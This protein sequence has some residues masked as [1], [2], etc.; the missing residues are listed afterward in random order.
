M[1]MSSHSCSPLRLLAT[2]YLFSFSMESPLLDT[3]HRQDRRTCGL[4][5]L[6]SLAQQ[7]VESQCAVA[8]LSAPL[9]F[10]AA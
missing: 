8:A 10:V 3:S 4:F 6:A 5:R 7:Q 1:P 9:L 2:T